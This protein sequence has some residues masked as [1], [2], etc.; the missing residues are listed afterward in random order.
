MD[1]PWPV[2]TFTIQAYR[3][4]YYTSLPHRLLYKLTTPF[5]IQA[6]HTVYY[7]SLP[8]QYYTSLPRQHYTSL[9][10]QYYTSLPRQYYTSLPRQYYTSLP[11]QDYTSLP[12]QY[13]TSLAGTKLGPNWNQKVLLGGHWR[14][15]GIPGASLGLPGTTRG[16]PPGVPGTGPAPGTPKVPK[17]CNGRHKQAR[18]QSSR[19][20]ATAP[21]IVHGF[22]VNTNE[23]FKHSLKGISPIGP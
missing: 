9:P 21:H 13:Y 18:G 5:T 2:A 14:S 1:S 23:T 17:V 22:S 15:L 20:R 11:R 8:R 3:T 12:R 4:V 16:G 6:Y 10:R 19:Q 7:T